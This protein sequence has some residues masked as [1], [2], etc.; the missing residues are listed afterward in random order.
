MDKK[1]SQEKKPFLKV[2][3]AAGKIGSRYINRNGNFLHSPDDRC[4]SM[5]KNFLKERAEKGLKLLSEKH[6][7]NRAFWLKKQKERDRLEMVKNF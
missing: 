3:K 2:F 1:A 5:E 6:E 4:K 7:S